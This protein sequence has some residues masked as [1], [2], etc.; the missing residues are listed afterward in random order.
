MSRRAISIGD[1]A[2]AAGVSHSTVSR[3]LHD[4][5]LI[6]VDVRENIQ[7]L[8]REMGYTPNAIAQSL[9]QQTTKT[10]GLVVTSIA[11]PFYADVVKG[12]EAEARNASMSVFLSAS[13]ND[14]EQELLVIET[15][16]R[17]RVDGIVVASSRISGSQAARLAHVR[18]PTVLLNS[19]DEALFDDMHSVTVDDYAGARQI[20]DHLIGLGH[21]AIGYI[22]AGNRPKANRRRCGGYRNALAHAGI[23]ARPDLVAVALAEDK[24][25]EDDVAVGYALLAPLL[26]AGATAVFCFND[27][28]AVGA[29][30]ACRERNI[31]VPQDLSVAGFDDIELAKY[32]SPPLTTIHQ[33]KVRLGR[34]AM[35]MLLD[36]LDDRPAENHILQPTLVE[37]AS[38]AGLGRGD[39]VSVKR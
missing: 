21:R 9:Q 7:R 6:S 35:R 38:T 14:P 31:A 24:Q 2:R 17:R 27:M 11:D 22:G 18:V 28:I 15:F 37:R 32:V 16:H 1:I 10:I 26:A 29:L 8:A 13:H 39:G 34:T 5:P 30:T 20:V 23:T 12:I 3:A 4:N 19:E 36:L 25:H 33:P